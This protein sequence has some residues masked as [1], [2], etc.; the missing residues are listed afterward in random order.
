MTW[1]WLAPLFGYLRSQD[2]PAGNLYRHLSVLQ[3]AALVTIEKG[4][5]G[6]RPR[7]WIEITKLGRT[8][9]QAEVAT[10]RAV[11]DAAEART[12]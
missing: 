10:V 2:L 12:R 9:F 1:A 5:L 7:T 4:C 11:L 3:G 6:R 8:A